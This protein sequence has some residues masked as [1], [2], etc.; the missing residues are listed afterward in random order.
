MSSKIKIPKELENIKNP[1]K[2]LYYKGDINLLKIK[3][4]SIVGS[5]HPIS[6]TKTFTSNL[7]NALKKRG[8]CVVSGGAMGVDSIAHKNA[9]P[10]TIGVMANSLDYIYPKVNYN[11]IKSM[12]KEA[13]VLSEPKR[14]I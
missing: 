2:E 9:F 4:V 11:L 12:E 7:A 10:F 5:R 1:P 14:S 6:Y 3:K 13:L 8:V